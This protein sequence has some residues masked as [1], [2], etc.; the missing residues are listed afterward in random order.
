[1]FDLV[2]ST[3]LKL[4]Q[5]HDIGMSAMFQHNQI[6]GKLVVN[7]VEPRLKNSEMEF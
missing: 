5:G 7:S 4:D 3:D 2:G 1:M 6:C